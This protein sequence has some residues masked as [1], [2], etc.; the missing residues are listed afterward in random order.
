MEPLR[1]SGLPSGLKGQG[2]RR[3]R[4]WALLCPR[5]GAEVSRKEVMSVRIAEKPWEGRVPGLRLERAFVCYHEDAVEM[6][7]D[8]PRPG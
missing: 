2:H 7:G 5:S 8:F 6:L 1:A 4:L 3:E